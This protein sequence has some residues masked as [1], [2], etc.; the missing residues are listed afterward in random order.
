MKRSQMLNHVS[1][2]LL[3]IGSA[4]TL[5]M[6]K[7]N[8]KALRSAGMVLINKGELRTDGGETVQLNAFLIDQNLVTVAEFN[9]FVTST[10][11]VTDAEKFGDAGVFNPALQAFVS[12]PGANYKFP[13]GKNMPEAKANHPVTQVS[14]NDANAFAHWRGKRLPTQHEWELAAVKGT[15]GLQEY[16]WGEHL[17]ENGK[18]KANTWQGSFPFYNSADD[19]Y[20]F[21]SPVGAFGT[22]SIGLADMGGN[23]WQW[24]SDVVEPSGSDKV[25]DP[26][27]RRALKGGSYLC[28]PLVCHGYKIFGRSSSTPESSMAHIGFRCVKDFE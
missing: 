22:N 3:G 20:E 16:A 24:C 1:L 8:P 6:Y 5:G 10:G 25:I 23:V 2:L 7:V 19:G 11:Y 18:H 17:I 15:N 9:E 14:W 13:F 12:V 28:D 27:P 4:F 26:A 21:T